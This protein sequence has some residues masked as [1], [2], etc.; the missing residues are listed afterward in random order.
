MKFSD[1]LSLLL[2]ACNYLY[3]PDTADLENLFCMLPLTS[4]GRASS[5]YV[6]NRS[7]SS[8]N[9]FLSFFHLLEHDVSSTM[10][11]NLILPVLGLNGS[12]W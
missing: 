12:D 11:T 4:D 9:A 1:L 8:V 7:I 3:L 2:L 10:I 5:F 6:V